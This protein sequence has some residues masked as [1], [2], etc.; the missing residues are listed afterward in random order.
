LALTF[1]SSGSTRHASGRLPSGHA[2][3]DRRTKPPASRSR[4]ALATADF[5]VIA[6]DY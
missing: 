6:S 1:I 4:A 5:L 3:R 2:Q